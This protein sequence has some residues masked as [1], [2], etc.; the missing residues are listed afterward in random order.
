MVAYSNKTTRRLLKHLEHLR[1]AL[2]EMERGQHSTAALKRA[3]ILCTTAYAGDHQCTQMLTEVRARNRVEGYN[4]DGDSDEETFGVEGGA[5]DPTL[6]A[7]LLT[8]EEWAQQEIPIRARQIRER[9]KTLKKQYDKLIRTMQNT[10][11]WQMENSKQQKLDMGGERELQSFMGKMQPMPSLWGVL[12]RSKAR[13]YPWVLNLTPARAHEFLDWVGYGV[14]AALEKGI[15][16]HQGRVFHMRRDGM[17]IHV[18]QHS[19]ERWK[20]GVQPLTAIAAFLE[21]VEMPTPGEIKL[22]ADPTPTIFTERSDKLSQLEFYEGMECTACSRKCVD[23]GTA[24][25]YPLSKVNQVG[26]REIDWWCTRCQKFRDLDFAEPDIPAWMTPLITVRKFSGRQLM[27]RTVDW[28]DW[29]WLILHLPRRKAGGAD[30]ITYELVRD[31]PVN[32]QAVIL[33]AVNAMLQG[34]PIPRD[35]KGGVVRMLNKREPVSQTENLRPI[36]LLQTT[37]KLFTTVINNRLQ[38]AM[39]ERAILENSQ[40][41]FR[42]GHQT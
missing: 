15:Q 24:D 2:L 4:S 41:G 13:H 22:E 9:Q 31:A 23:C 25:L 28:R 6:P 27:H 37:Y 32:L 36:T 17:T 21:T 10:S 33:N 18:F 39:E 1:R 11:I 8:T 7:S 12:P 42:P 16:Q 38:R 34:T 19:A 40:D 35:Q 20:L 5:A 3:A 26:K 29:H 14:K 30:G